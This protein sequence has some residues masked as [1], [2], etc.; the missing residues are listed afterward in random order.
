MLA[1]NKLSKYLLYAV[2]EIMLVVIGILIALQINNWNENKKLKRVEIGMLKEIKSS[3]EID[4]EDLNA[5]QNYLRRNFNS[6]NIFIDWIESG[7]SF[8]DSIS[9]HLYN[10]QMSIEFR[11][12]SAPYETLKQLGMNII[13]NDSLRK[14]IS[15]LYDL[16][17]ENYTI[18]IEARRRLSNKL[19]DLE[20]PY[21]NEIG[22][23]NNTV[24]KPIDIVGIR[25]DNV[26]LFTL[27][28]FKNYDEL[29]INFFIPR[30]KK[31]IIKTKNDIEEEIK[32]RS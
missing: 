20:A 24:M 4:L 6:E 5:E 3:L 2:G 19:Q 7:D 11:Y 14:Q 29:L 28:S 26:L 10:I 15:L 25:Q 23:M 17:Y 30:V 18:V 1:E 8:N 27:K 31:E 9:K 21:F 22:F 32:N 13:K 16:R 12:Q